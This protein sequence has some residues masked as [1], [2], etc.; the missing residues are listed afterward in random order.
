MKDNKTLL[1][2]IKYKL[3]KYQNFAPNDPIIR[4]RLELQ[5]KP[6]LELFYISCNILNTKKLKNSPYKIHNKEL[7]DIQK[8][9]EKI[10]KIGATTKDYDCNIDVSKYKSLMKPIKSNRN[11]INVTITKLIEI[12][13]LP[14]IDN[15][16]EEVITRFSAFIDNRT[17]EQKLKN[18]YPDINKKAMIKLKAINQ[19]THTIDLKLFN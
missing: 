10:A 5:I 6:V 19:I 12:S 3:T 8:I 7:E 13:R 2:L 15:N 9:Y 1:E 14:K 16:L 4:D 18:I 11:L 17:L